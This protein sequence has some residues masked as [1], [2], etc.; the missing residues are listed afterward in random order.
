MHLP[1]LKPRIG[2][3][4]LVFLMLGLFQPAL[5]QNSAQPQREQLLNGLR[6]L[7][8]PRP[9]SQDLVIKLRIHSGAAFDL[10]GRSGQMALL[11]DLLF[12]D[13]ATIEY[14]T[15]EMNGRLDVNVDYD[16][17]TITMQGKTSELER[18]LE[19][20]RNALISTQLTPEVVA[21][22]RE[23]RIK[24]VRETTIAPPT[25]AD[26]AVASRLFGDYPYGRPPGGS[27][28]DLSRVER[29]DLMLAR[30]RFLNSNNA[31]LAIIGD[32][33][34]P[35]AMRALRQLLGPWRKS[36]QIVPQTFR[37]PVAPDPR[38]L[39][40]NGPTD[41]AELRLAVRG[42]SRSDPDHYSAKILAKLVQ[43]RWET[44]MPQLTKRP[45]FAR[46]E[47]HFLPGMFVMGAAV[48][49]QSLPEAINSVKKVIDS[50][51]L[52]PVAPEEIDR[53][54]NEVISDL[55]TRS[56]KPDALSDPFLDIDT[57]R[58]ASIEDP[59]A[60]MNKLTPMDIQRLAT[61]LLKTPMATVVTGDTSQLKS[62]L[63]GRIQFEVLG[64]IAQ[65]VKPANPSVRP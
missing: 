34:K 3:F 39:L 21:R 45:I 2:R 58:L 43:R 17:I 49:Y 5:G 54:R 23:A 11:G 15:E 26:R 44:Q 25:L 16:S 13:R 9:G 64:E 18:I 20:L 7:L 60:I 31:T 19:L 62:A 41:V 6:L 56:A 24:I 42:V 38:V 8:W 28:E 22:M 33:S 55:A 37:Q 48:D 36:E 10:S 61:K 65:P 12:P 63:Q 53:A 4:F 29:A 14:F 46:S 32:I 51:T 35:R 27:V 1:I 30:T 47:S 52:A 59:V 50:F 57:Y 40:I